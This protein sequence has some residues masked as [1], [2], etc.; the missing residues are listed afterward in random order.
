MES[1]LRSVT[2]NGSDFASMEPPTLEGTCFVGQAANGR[3]FKSKMLMR[4]ASGGEP[5]DKLT[6]LFVCGR[7]PSS[8]PT[9]YAGA[10]RT[11]RSTPILR[12]SITPR[13]RIRGRRG[14]GQPV[15]RSFCARWS[16]VLSASEVGRTKRLVR[17]WARSHFFIRV[18]SRPFAV[19]GNK[20]LYG[21]NTQPD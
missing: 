12:H 10:I 9:R 17:R 20:H 14:R 19:E 4:P 8:I 6:A 13:G 3:E 1:A 5:L 16:A 18:H 7:F 11:W 15:R 21:S 2:A